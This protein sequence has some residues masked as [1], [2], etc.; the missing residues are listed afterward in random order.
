MEARF[1]A[2]HTISHEAR[3]RVVHYEQDMLLHRPIEA[4]NPVA[5]GQTARYA[6]TSSFG[7]EAVNADAKPVIKDGRAEL[8]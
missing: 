7:F 3:K 5:D 2:T 1:I 8:W 6:A 4:E